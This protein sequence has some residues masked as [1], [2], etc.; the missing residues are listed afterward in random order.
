VGCKLIPADSNDAK[1]LARRKSYGSREVL[2]YVHGDYPFT[3]IKLAAVRPFLLSFIHSLIISANY[4]KCPFIVN[5]N[6]K[7]KKKKNKKKNKIAEVL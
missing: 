7:K 3:D 1:K 5:K 2:C 6:K 4:V